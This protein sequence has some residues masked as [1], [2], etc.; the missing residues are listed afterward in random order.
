MNH[1]GLVGMRMSEVNSLKRKKI[2]PWSSA[3]I[4]CSYIFLLDLYKYY[5]SWLHSDFLS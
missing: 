1:N 5:N 3:R 4:V 2:D